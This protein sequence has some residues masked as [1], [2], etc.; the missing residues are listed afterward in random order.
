MK[1]QL[2]ILITGAI[3]IGIL[4]PSNISAQPEPT[5][6]PPNCRSNEQCAEL[7]DNGKSLVLY[8]R[9]QSPVG[10]Q[11]NFSYAAI[12]REISGA[13]DYIYKSNERE[14]YIIFNVGVSISGHH[15]THH[16]EVGKNTDWDQ[17]PLGDQIYKVIGDVKAP[18]GTDDSG[19]YS[20]KPFVKG[21]V[22]LNDGST[23]KVAQGA[24]VDMWL[25]SGAIANGAISESKGP[26]IG[27]EKVGDSSFKFD[28]KGD[29][30]D[31]NMIFLSL[32]TVKNIVL[33]ASYEDKTTGKKY[34]KTEKIAFSQDWPKST[35]DDKALTKDN[36]QINFTAQDEVKDWIVKPG[37]TFQGPITEIVGSADWKTDVLKN[38]VCWIRNF[39][40]GA[41]YWLSIIAA[42][43]LK[44]NY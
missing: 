11:E 36:V 12:A 8:Y 1:I 37:A 30:W 9:E 13:G 22:N 20:W 29:I 16:F 27:T 38:V 2:K 24:I 19:R 43:F 7:K 4:L 39:F 42:G 14:F 5:N 15:V 3:I 40:I 17:V 33:C 6:R 21:T 35:E 26:K 32:Y 18:T 28:R 44:R 10:L 23:T 41:F 25:N 34:Q 31:Y